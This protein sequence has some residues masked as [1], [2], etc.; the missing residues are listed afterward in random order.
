M[1][2]TLLVKRYFDLPGEQD[3]P[4]GD[5]REGM[6]VCR[7]ESRLYRLVTEG[8]GLLS[9]SAEI[10]AT[11]RFRRIK[12]LPAPRVSL[13]VSL[14]SGLL[15]IAIDAGELDLNELTQV[16]DSYRS[17]KRYHRLRDGRFLL[18]DSASDSGAAPEED[19]ADGRTGGLEAL[20]QLARRAGSHRQAAGLGTPC[21]PPVPGCLSGRGAPGFPP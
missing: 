10:Y 5:L 15:D 16:L 4:G 1:R 12:A 19:G 17:H 6:L 7:E 21:R 3:A 20:S 14:T 8:I 2:V 9:R 11:D 18:L 13:G